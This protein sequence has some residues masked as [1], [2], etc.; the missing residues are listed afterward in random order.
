MKRMVMLFILGM[1][2][3]LLNRFYGAQI[4]THESFGMTLVFFLTQTFVLLRLDRKTTNEARITT[5][6]LKIAIRLLSALV[7]M[8]FLFFRFEELS[9]VLF[10]QFV[11]LY[12]VFMLFEIVTV[13][14]NL[15]R[16]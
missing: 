9:N 13:L 3:Y 16:N 15:R 7:F 4:P 2:L 10:I 1:V 14:S 11:I 6:M 5:G 12:L 8:L